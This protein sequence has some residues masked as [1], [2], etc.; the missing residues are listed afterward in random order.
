MTAEFYIYQVFLAPVKSW[1]D[2]GDS[3]ILE[4]DQDSAHGVGKKSSVRQAK[5]TIGLEYFFNASGSPDLSPIKN[6]W[7]AEKQQIKD[8]DHLDNESLARAICT[9]QANIS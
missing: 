8:F 3:F 7:R 4:E 2:H 5:E 6:I 1:L 9:A